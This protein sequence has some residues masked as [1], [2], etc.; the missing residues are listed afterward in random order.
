MTYAL[1]ERTI[2]YMSPYIPLSGKLDHK[3]AFYG[4]SG[5]CKILIIVTLHPLVFEPVLLTNKHFTI[6]IWFIFDT[7]K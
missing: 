3:S 7:E 4:L 5:R 2:F 6:R 1:L